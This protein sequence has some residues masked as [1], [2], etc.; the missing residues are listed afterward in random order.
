METKGKGPTMAKTKFSLPKDGVVEPEGARLI[1]DTDV[2]GHGL[3]ITA[4]PSLG[5][6]TPGHGGENIPMPMDD[7]D[8]VEGHRVPRM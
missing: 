4:P 6:R 8:D 7:G 3:P 5:K 2:E 1:D